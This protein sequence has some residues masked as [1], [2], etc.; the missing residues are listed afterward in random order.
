MHPVQ[1]K[2]LN[3][4]ED[5][6]LGKMSLRQMAKLID[7]KYPETIKHHLNQLIKKGFLKGSLNSDKIEKVKRG[8]IGDSD[9]I[10]IPILGRANCGPANIFADQCLQGYL[11]ISKRVIDISHNKDRNIF[12]I[13]ASGNSM[14]KAN[15]NGNN[16]EDGDYVIIDGDNHNPKDRDYVLSVIDETA[17]IKK[18]FINKN[19]KQIA[20]LAESTENYSPIIIH[21]DDKFIING[22]IRNVI[23]KPK[24]DWV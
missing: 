24:M 19:K 13:K 23:K 4:S 20:L 14:N 12:A 10:N 15:I 11:K 1:I 8:K 18:I 2:L 21:P 3:L 9:L 7:E 16:I 5:V 6:N 17:N 22:I